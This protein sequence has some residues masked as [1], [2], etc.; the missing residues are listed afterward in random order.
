MIKWI[1]EEIQNFYKER[2]TIQSKSIQEKEMDCQ[3]F[4]RQLF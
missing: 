3:H 1:K 2:I 4:I